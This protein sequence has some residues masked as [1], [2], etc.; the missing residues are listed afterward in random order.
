MRWLDDD[1][2]P[3]MR[4]CTDGFVVPCGA[5]RY[6]AWRMLEERVARVGLLEAAELGAG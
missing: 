4:R 6:L 5:G 3:A 2:P 1:A